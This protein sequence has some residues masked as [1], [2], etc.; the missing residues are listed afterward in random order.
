MLCVGKKGLDQIIRWGLEA[1]IG[2][3]RMHIYYSN[4]IWILKDL[5]IDEY[6]F[7]S[8]RNERI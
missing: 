1:G 8:N 3:H 7:Q 6:K 4:T 5:G 2:R